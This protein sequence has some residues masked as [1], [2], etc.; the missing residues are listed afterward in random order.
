LTLNL[1]LFIMLWNHLIQTIDPKH[2]NKLLH[3]S[4]HIKLHLDGEQLLLIDI[5][6]IDFYEHSNSKYFSNQFHNQF[7][8]L[9]FF[10]FFVHIHTKIFLIESPKSLEI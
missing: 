6:F 7:L 10:S 5:C 1:S 3:N 2:H 9:I 8:L 4:D